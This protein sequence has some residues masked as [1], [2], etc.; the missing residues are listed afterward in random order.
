MN[1]KNLFI[2]I[3][4]LFLCFITNPISADAKSTTI[5]WSMTPSTTEL[6]T[7]N[8][9]IIYN[10]CHENTNILTA[11]YVIPANSI[12]KITGYC[13]TKSNG[14]WYKVDF[15]GISGYS[16]RTDFAPIFDWTQIKNLLL[17]A[18]NNNL[19]IFTDDQMLSYLAGTL[20]P[21]NLSTMQKVKNVHDY[22]CMNMSYDTTLTYLTT[23]DA[24]YRGSGVCQ[25]YAN[26]FNDI[27]NRAGIKTEFIGGV[28]INSDGLPEVH[29][30]NRCLVGNT[31]YY[32]DTTWDD[33]GAFAG[34]EFFWTTDKTFNHTHVET[35]IE[36]YRK[37]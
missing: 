17:Q 29:A 8:N 35:D 33:E 12:V 22:L 18:S 13:E 25:A 9:S 16:L 32:I 10:G 23:H 19:E 31:Y 6:I 37:R 5:S 2:T 11:K 7:I 1:K 26:A 24:L 27:L 4:S 20:C 21:P 30:W 14:L 28:A 3:L 15:N 36:P 34:N